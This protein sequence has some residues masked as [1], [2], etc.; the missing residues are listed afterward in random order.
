MVSSDYF[1]VFIPIICLLINVSIQV[2]IFRYLPRLGL[3][4]SEYIGFVIGII[5]FLLFEFYPLIINPR[6][7]RDFFAIFIT[8]LITYSSLGYCYFHFV[9]L[10]ETARRI[11]ILRELYDSKNGLSLEELLQRYN[12]EE[13]LERRISRMLNNRQIILKEER[14]YIASPALLLMARAITMMKQIIL[15][16]RSEFD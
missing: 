10:G 9:N 4:K 7:T 16:K 3:L 1:Q 14:Y 11:R 12:A 2:F 5:F 13:I 15:G 6:I 8:N